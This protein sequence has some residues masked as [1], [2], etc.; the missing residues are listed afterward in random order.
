MNKSCQ[1]TTLSNQYQSYKI[2]LLIIE[3]FWATKT[4]LLPSFPLASPSQ[5]PPLLAPISM[6]TIMTS[7]HILYT[8]WPLGGVTRGNKIINS[9]QWNTYF[10]FF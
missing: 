3:V 7:F 1:M 6:I 8:C 2:L 5:N 4:L 10:I 9:C